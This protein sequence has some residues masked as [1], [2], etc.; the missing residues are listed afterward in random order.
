MYADYL[1]SPS[2][3]S[4]GGKQFKQPGDPAKAHI[5]AKRLLFDSQLDS[6]TLGEEDHRFSESKG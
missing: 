4:N 2:N 1:P 5:T 3:L 6:D